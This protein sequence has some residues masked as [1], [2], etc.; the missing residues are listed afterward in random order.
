[1]ALRFNETP[2]AEQQ[3]LT[4]IAHYSYIWAQQG[5]YKSGNGQPKEK[6]SRS[7]KS[8]GML[9]SCAENLR[10]EEMSGKIE[11]ISHSEFNDNKSWSI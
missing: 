7:G 3:K 9:I 1:M 2:Y 10:F 5:C 6:F 11:I 4:V 8:Q